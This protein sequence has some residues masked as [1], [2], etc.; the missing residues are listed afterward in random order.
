MERIAMSQE[1]RD[2]LEWLKRAKGGVITQRQ[3][4]A[5]MGVSDRWVRKLL[6][7]MKTDGDAVVVH[8]RRGR[9]SNRRIEEQTQEARRGAFL[10][11]A[12]E[13]I[14][15]V[16]AVGHVHSRLAGGAR[17]RTLPGEVD[18]RWHQP[19]WGT[20]RA[21]RRDAGEHGRAMA[22]RGR[23][24]ANGGSVHRPGGDLHGGAAGQGKRPAAPGSGSL[25]AVRPRP[26]RGGNRL[27]PGILAAGQGLR[28]TLHLLGTSGND[29]CCRQSFGVPDTLSFPWWVLSGMLI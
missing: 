11:T 10:A 18:R 5:K 25:N 4:A 29:L 28:F 13:R 19:Q 12:A 6:A 21:A 16:G 26:A 14:R 3:A 17:G 2:W 7:R 1:E 24:R 23:Q 22:V 8:G 15:R 20:V 9:S 27:D